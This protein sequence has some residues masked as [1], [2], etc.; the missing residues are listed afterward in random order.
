M[1]ALA[2]LA[3]A[4]A[5]ALAAPAGAPAGGETDIRHDATVDAVQRV[6]P[7]VVNIGT[8]TIVEVSDPFEELFRQYYGP[9]Y[10]IAPS[11]G[12]GMIIDDDG[13]ILTNWH[14][15][16][17]ARRI[18]VKLSEEEG[19]REY[20]AELI[21]A[22]PGSDV[23]LIRI[24]QSPK[25]K[26]RKFKAIKMAKDDDLLMGETVLALGNPFGLGGSVSKGILS[27][28]Q[29]AIPKENE[30]LSIENWLQTDAS[31]N[32]GNSG[33]PIINL[34]GE[35]IG[36]SEAI[37]REAQGIG[38]AIPIKEVR[39]ALARIFTPE[40]KARWFG[41]VVRP[42]AVPLEVETVQTNSPA[43][44]A[45]LT[46]GD[47]ILLVNGKSPSGF[48]FHR[49]LR[50]DTNSVFSLT[51]QRGNEKK[52]VSVRL[53]GYPEILR[54]RL[55]LDAQELRGALARQFGLD[56]FAGLLI[57]GVEKD[58]PAATADLRRNFLITGIGDARVGSF[59]D[60]VEAIKDKA[61]G[62]SVDVYLLAPQT[63][64]EEILGYARGSTRL[65]LR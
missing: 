33:G 61:A 44:K 34:K 47:R 37:L 2:G 19:G 1:G 50:D 27:S 58:G 28:K 20:E 43:A 49:W 39:Q 3:A 46:A 9:R 5:L 62:D 30:E 8:E 48:E 64:G 12:S 7:C 10:R 14:V 57:A 51:V 40:S 16:R 55:G 56:E 35:M 59:S 63:R 52:D 23:A 22:I 32:P 25:E 36:M 18:Q 4:C 65:K 15:V 54:Q 26:P 6:M 53:V 41:A 45:G 24:V 42:A 11:L 17:R 29:R 60:L 31:I 21:S 13:Y 38:F